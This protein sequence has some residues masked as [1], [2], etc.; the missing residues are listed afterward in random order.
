MSKVKK[1]CVDDNRFVELRNLLDSLA[2]PFA[3][4]T[5]LEPELE[6]DFPLPVVKL[7]LR[8]LLE[9]HLALASE[10]NRIALHWVETVN[11]ANLISAMDRTLAILD[12]NELIDEGIYGYFTEDL[13]E[14][15][16]D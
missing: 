11:R 3:P 10:T 4:M 13:F 1:L 6:P 14:G 16:D 15:L 9:N 5:Q 7:E 12:E 8:S 2:G